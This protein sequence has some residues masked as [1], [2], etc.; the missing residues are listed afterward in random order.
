[1]TRPRAADD[2]AVI[3][4]CLEER[5]GVGR[6]RAATTSAAAISHPKRRD[7]ERQPAASGAG[8]APETLPIKTPPPDARVLTQEKPHYPGR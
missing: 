3:R 6:T 7:A 8:D 1:M 5:A 2:F 4:A